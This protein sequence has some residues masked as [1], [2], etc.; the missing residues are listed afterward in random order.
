LLLHISSLYNQIKL[1][2]QN[3][4]M[5]LN[6]DSDSTISVPCNAAIIVLDSTS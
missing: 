1:I 3:V 5:L 6:C 2:L 4:E